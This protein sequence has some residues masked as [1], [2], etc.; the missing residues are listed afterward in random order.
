M[1]Q[2]DSIGWASET[3]IKPSMQLEPNIDY[4]LGV[5]NVNSNRTHLNQTHESFV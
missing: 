4:R 1:R 5:T 3:D 2:G